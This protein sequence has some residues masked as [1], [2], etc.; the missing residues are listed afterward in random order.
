MTCLILFFCTYSKKNHVRKL[1]KQV[2]PSKMSFSILH[3]KWQVGG[4]QE[5]RG[6][7]SRRGVRGELLTKIE[8]TKR[9]LCVTIY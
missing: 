8:E 6:V 2:Y 4:G 5:L 9:T 1:S 7:L 3:I